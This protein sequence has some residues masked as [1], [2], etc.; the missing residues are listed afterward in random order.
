MTTTVAPVVGDGTTARSRAAQRWRRLRL[1]LA[2]VGL[3]ALAGLLAVLPAPRTS[4]DPYAPDNPDPTGARAAAEILRAQGVEID[5]TRRLAEAVRDARDGSTLLVVGGDLVLDG[6]AVERLADTDA[7]LVVVDAPFTLETLTDGALQGDGVGWETP[8]AR[9]AAC[10]D[11]DA[12]A[13][14]TV[15]ATGG[16]RATSSDA[17]VCFPA[18]GDAAG[19][20]AYGVVDREQRVVGFAD[21][22]MLTNEHLASEGNAALVLRALG[23]HDHLVWYI[24]SYD[25]LGM[26]DDEAG[27]GL[28]ALVPPVVP[29]IGL[30]LLLV[31]LAAAVWRGRRLGR[32]VDEPLPV[33]VPAAE[34]TRGRGRLYRRSRSRAHAAAALRAGTAA[35][36]ARRLGLA[37]SADAPVLIEAVERAT[38]RPGRDVEALLYGPP[39]HDDLG[40]ARLA[41]ALDHLESEV[42]RS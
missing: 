34:T 18:E 42:H 5:Y 33:V 22:A 28:G 12:V 17:V 10:D 11:P 29:L 41:Q 14:G 39:P 2:I 36:C 26:A 7:D 32:V 19:A 38:G 37:R 27:P 20:G 25:D 31:T 21:G 9:A 8:T 1:P 13:A 6:D 35:R 24:P 40:L 4:T 23:R 30:H 16:L 15:T 3:L